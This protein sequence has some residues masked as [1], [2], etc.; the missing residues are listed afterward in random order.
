MHARYV[1][2]LASRERRRELPPKILLVQRETETLRHILLKLFGYVLFHRERVQLEARLDDHYLQYTPDVVQLDY[3]GRIALWVECGECGVEKLDRLAVKAP[4]AEIWVVKASASAARD[5]LHQMER[6][7]LRRERY[8]IVALDAGMLEEVA[9][10]VTARNDLVWHLG[11]FDPPRMQFEFNGLWF[12]SEF[13]V[14]E[15]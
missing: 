3:Q 4:Y 5:L 10:L 9:G 14:F 8:R 6:Q 7:K 2:N 1:F 11:L 13:E 12:E 15:H